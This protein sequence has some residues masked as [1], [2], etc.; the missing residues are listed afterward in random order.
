MKVSVL[1]AV[2]NAEK[3]L[4]ACLDS[5]VGQ[6]HRDI[7]IICIDD[8]S[9]DA[10]WQILEEYAAKDSRIVLL[11][12]AENRGQ[13]EA[14]NCGLLVADGDYVTM[15]DSDDWFLSN[16]LELACRA[17]SE[18]ECNDCVLFDVLHYEEETAKEWGYEYRT[19]GRAWDGEEAFRLSLDWSIHGLYMVRRSIHVQYPYDTASRLYSDDN[20]TRLHFLHSRQVVRCD[21]VY[22]YR[23]HAASMTH[24][25]TPLR[26]LYLDANYSMKQTCLAEGVADPLLD[27]Y[28]EHRWRSLVGLYVFYLTHRHAFSSEEQRSIKEKLRHYHSTIEPHRLPSS[29]KHKFGYIPSPSF[30]RLYEV[31]IRLYLFVRR[32]FYHLR[33]KS[34]PEE[35]M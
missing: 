31:Q 4:P 5:L 1:V 10:S 18:D 2:Y 16:A 15:L 25:V 17:A 22:V 7:Q 30:P 19:A 21:G 27:Q 24:A 8:A 11:R 14:R 34:S 28:E 6:T 12:Q 9:T 26:F 32:L 33:G 23:Q 13:A 35:L 20:T 29:L 3:Y